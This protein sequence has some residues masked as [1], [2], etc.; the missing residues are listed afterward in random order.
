MS[1][2]S[3][4][5]LPSFLFII[6]FLLDTLDSCESFASDNLALVITY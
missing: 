3:H 5:I 2:R 1:G 6:F 4:M